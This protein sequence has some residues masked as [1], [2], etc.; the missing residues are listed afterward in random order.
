MGGRGAIIVI[1]AEGDALGDD[2]GR[3]MEAMAIGAA[4]TRVTMKNHV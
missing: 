4:P 1:D 2:P 3:I